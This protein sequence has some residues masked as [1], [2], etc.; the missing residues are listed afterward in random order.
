MF[1][2]QSLV[3]G[4]ILFTGVLIVKNDCVRND[5][6]LIPATVYSI[7][8]RIFEVASLTKG[9]TV[10]EESN[11]CHSIISPYVLFTIFTTPNLEFTG[12]ISSEIMTIF[13]MACRI[14]TLPGGLIPKTE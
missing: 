2:V 12:M 9:H 8:N 5:C 7:S 14:L 1:F 11:Y 3:L 13:V 6:V 10:N 4:D